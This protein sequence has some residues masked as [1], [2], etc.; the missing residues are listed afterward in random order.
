MKEVTPPLTI[1]MI[2]TGRDSLTRK[3][4]IGVKKYLKVA[5]IKTLMIFR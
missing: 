4:K 3:A 5:S 2:V 1:V